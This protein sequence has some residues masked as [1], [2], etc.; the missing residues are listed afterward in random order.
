MSIE[1]KGYGYGSKYANDPIGSDAPR[2]KNRELRKHAMD[3]NT[4]TPTESHIKNNLMRQFMRNPE[5]T[6]QSNTEAYK[7]SP[8]WCPR[9]ERRLRA[10]DSEHCG[11]CGMTVKIRQTLTP[12]DVL[13]E[14]AHQG[15]D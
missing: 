14:R 10:D 7:N 1:K 8:A 6:A 9:C 15:L 2:G 12:V 4:M 5:G 3:G 11:P 13:L